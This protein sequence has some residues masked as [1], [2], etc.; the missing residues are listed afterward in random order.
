M[1]SSDPNSKIDLLDPPED[2]RKKKKA[3]F[4]E[5]GNIAENGLLSFIQAVLIPI[6]ELHLER[7]SS[8]ASRQSP[9]VL[10]GAPTGTVFTIHRDAKYG[11]PSHYTSFEDLQKDFAEK[12]LHPGDLKASVTNAINA[13]LQP[14]RKAYEENEEWQSVAKLAYPDPKA[15]VQKKKKV[16]VIPKR[17]RGLG[18]NISQERVFH[19]PPPGKG[20][21]VNGTGPPAPD[22]PE[23]IE[24]KG[25][26]SF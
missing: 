15:K 12:Q 26:E 19:P 16:S 4:C 3:A 22:A 9:F 8:Q 2:V 21:N 25:I 10:D 17:G 24:K 5:E 1:S 7:E 18:F 20:K 6:S 13:L 23:S 11:G 14:I